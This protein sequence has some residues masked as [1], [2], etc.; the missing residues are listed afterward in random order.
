MKKRNLLKSALFVGVVA[1]GLSSCK[2]KCE[3]VTCQTGYVC[4]DGKCVTDPNATTGNEVK[5]GKITANETW[6]ADKIYEIKGRVIVDGGATLTI[7]PGTIIKGQTGEGAS[8]SA[9]VVARGARIMAKGTAAKPIIFTSVLDNIKIGEKTGTNLKETDTKKWGGVIVLGN[10][11]VSVKTGGAEGQIEGIPADE[12]YGKYGGTNVADNSGVITYISIR[13]GGALIGEGNEINGLTLGGVGNGTKIE[14]VEVVATLDDGIECFGGSVNITNALVVYQGDDALDVDQNYSGTFD[15]AYVIYNNTGDE[16]L[17]IDGPESNVNTDGL[18]TIKNSTFISKTNDGTVD[19][20][21]KAQGT[22]KNCKFVG[23]KEFK[24][25]ASF[26][27]DC[28]TG[29]SDAYD[30]Y[31]AATPTLKVTGNNTDAGIK[32]YT[33]SEN[34]SGTK[35]TLPANYQT[36]ADAIYNA[37]GNGSSVSGT[38]ADKSVFDGWTW[39]AIN[40]KF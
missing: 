7:E 34:S 3:D 18:F 27:N 6:T 17:E 22:I 30:R 16:F 12:S 40:N 33:K 36:D 20:K 2:D 4:Q 28:V 14:N 11:P 13:H 39:T 24:L 21:S 8:A 29:K 26:E 25:S 15:N 1:L 5:T 10:A 31:T 19:L 23:L 38:G 37:A 9:L 32:V 35:C